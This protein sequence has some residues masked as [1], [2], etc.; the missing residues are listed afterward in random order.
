MCRGAKP[1]AQPR[2]PAFP[3]RGEPRAEQGPAVRL[4]RRQRHTHHTSSEQPQNWG[5]RAAL[6]AGR[7]SHQTRKAR[8]ESEPMAARPRAVHLRQRPGSPQAEEE[9]SDN[10]GRRAPGLRDRREPGQPEVSCPAL[11]KLADRSRHCAPERRA[12]APLPARRPLNGLPRPPRDSALPLPPHRLPRWPRA[13]R[14]L[15]PSQRRG[16]Q[17]FGAGRGRISCHGRPRRRRRRRPSRHGCGTTHVSSSRCSSV[18]PPGARPPW[19]RLQS[20]GRAPS[21]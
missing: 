2:L 10:V 1:A 17:E 4:P 6:Q 19:S 3:E 5:G 11:A 20:F 15:M 7:I 12:A 8:A 14:R 21:R 16:C 13:T 18:S 9:P